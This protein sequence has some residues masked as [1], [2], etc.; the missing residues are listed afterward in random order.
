MLLILQHVTVVEVRDGDLV[1][2][3][4]CCSRLCPL[5]HH[6]AATFKEVIV[7]NDQVVH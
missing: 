4:H 5:A 7:F 6:R 1:L 3:P 2:P